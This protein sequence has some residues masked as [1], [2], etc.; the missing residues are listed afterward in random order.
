M[1]HELR[2]GIMSRQVTSMWAKRGFGMCMG[3]L[4][5]Q[6]T[7]KTHKGLIR[8]LSGLRPIGLITS[9]DQHYA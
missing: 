2:E 7:N 4:N 3:C 5:T 1:S 6:A 8:Y 9:M